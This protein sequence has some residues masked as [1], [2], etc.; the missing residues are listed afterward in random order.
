MHEEDFKIIP[1][2]KVLKRVVNFALANKGNNLTPH[3]RKVK[4][5]RNATR[6]IEK[7]KKTRNRQRLKKY[8]CK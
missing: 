7:K 6:L 3:D 8:Y 4:N 2:K 1:E 5:A